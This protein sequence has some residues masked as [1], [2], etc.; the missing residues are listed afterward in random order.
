MI[1]EGLQIYNFAQNLT[2]EESVAMRQ[3]FYL[4]HHCSWI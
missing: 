1:G 2:S 4:L 3:T